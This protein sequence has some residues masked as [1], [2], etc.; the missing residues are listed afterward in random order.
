MPRWLRIVAMVVAAAAASIAIVLGAAWA[1]LPRD[2]ISQ[3]AQRQAARLSGASVRWKSLEPGLE[4][5]SIGV[6]L[7]GFAYRAPAEGEPEID[8]RAQEVFVRFK[9]LPLLS[10]R[11]E[12]AAARVRGAG[13]ATW[14]RASQAG[15]PPPPAT[16]DGGSGMTLFLPRLELDGVDIRTRDRNGGGIDVRRLRG[17]TDISGSIQAPKGVRID[18]SADSLFWKGSAREPRL[19][20]PGPLRVDVAMK[21]ASGKNRLEVAHGEV[22]LGDLRSAVSGS[23]TMPPPPAPALLDLLIKGGPADWKSSDPLFQ[24]LAAASPATWSTK[25]SW[26]V[27]IGGTAVAV[28]QRGIVTLR[29][30]EVAAEGNRVTFDE[31]RV[32]WST[33]TDRTFTAHAKGGGSGLSVRLEA[34]GSMEPGG[35]TSGTLEVDAPAARLNGLVPDMP[36]WKAGTLAVRALFSMRAPAPPQIRWTVTG[37]DLSGTAPGVAQPIRRLAFQLAGDGKKID[38]RS[39]NATVGS[40]TANVKGEVISGKPLGTGAFTVHVDRFVT[41]EWAPPAAAKGKGTPAASP[42]APPPLLPFRLLTA[43]VTIGE[44]RQGGMTVRDV[45]VPVRYEDAA[46]HVD[47]IRG[48]VGEGTITGSLTVTDLLAAPAY[49]LR[50]AIQKAPVGEVARG[51]VPFDLGISGILNGDV[52][53]SGPGLPGPEVGESLRG[54]V[55]GTVEQG[56]LIDNTSLRSIRNALG[57]GADAEMA[58][59][60]I[61]HVLRIE[62]GRLLLDKVRGDLGADKFELSGGLGLDKSLDLRLLV[63]LAPARLQGGGALRELAQYARDADGRIPVELGIGG[64]TEK[65]RVQLKAGKLLDV[66]GQG[67]R[68]SLTKSLT[69]RLESAARDAKADSLG[70]QADS[71]GGAPDSAAEDP[72]RK[73]REALR[74]LLGK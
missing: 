39:M 66:A 14:E 58:F 35:A 36:V 63:R 41:E 28:V 74:K 43:D 15:T 37:R 46:L 11:V 13:I 40:S 31:F 22:S 23:V 10:R 25:A 1:L 70:G 60:T 12:V 20:L 29:P 73:G 64:T 19:T 68:E 59:K 34:N 51:L 61:T 9:L 71:T 55:S 33:A 2:W 52:E 17:S 42:A 45:S 7:R 57:I 24:S 8:A 16:A 56:R 44:L 32:D 26:E 48:S 30:I 6:R 69:S 72:L 47:P 54:S 67:L 18:V 49:A 62:R 65:P 5:F 4:G 53:L 3:E 38:V 27:K 50:L 21:A